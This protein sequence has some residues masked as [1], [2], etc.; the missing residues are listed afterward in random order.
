MPA[1]TVPADGADFLGRSRSVT[2][3]PSTRSLWASCVRCGSSLFRRTVCP[4]QISA[5]V[6][7]KAVS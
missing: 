6:V 7:R 2:T 1:T 3:P 4:C 5:V